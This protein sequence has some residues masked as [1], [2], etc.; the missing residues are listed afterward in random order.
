MIYRVMISYSWDDINKRE[1]LA[2]AIRQ[3]PGVEVLY[4]QEHIYP[5]DEIH[6]TISLMLSDCNALLVLLTDAGMASSEVREEMIRAHTLKKT[7]IPVI[8][9]NANKKKMPWYL[10]DTLQIDYIE[11]DFNSTITAVQQAI[12]KKSKAPKK[13]LGGGII[14]W[15]EITEYVEE[16]AEGLRQKF[17][18]PDILVSFPKGGLIVADLL[19][20]LFENDLDVVTLHTSR[21]I[22]DKKYTLSIRDSYINYDGLNGKKILII[23]DV[24][25]N[26]KTVKDVKE[27]IMNKGKVSEKDIRIAVLGMTNPAAFTLIEPDIYIFEYMRDDQHDLVFPWG[28]VTL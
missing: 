20:H 18:K 23:D 10:S 13:F 22:I 5:S 26:G 25:E 21:E 28:K 9:K 19:G 15:Q 14:T 7:I 2:S 24:L 4:D 27:L 3:I 16:I 8:S 11:N 1:E 17:F 12:R 6:T